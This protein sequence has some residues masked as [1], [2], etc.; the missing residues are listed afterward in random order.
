MEQ[1]KVITY[2]KNVKLFGIYQ[3]R[4]LEPF[5]TSGIQRDQMGLK[6]KTHTLPRLKLRI[7]S[8]KTDSHTLRTCFTTMS[9]K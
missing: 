4:M 5:Q 9:Q 3:K 7:L 2:R 8:V 6:L 1:E